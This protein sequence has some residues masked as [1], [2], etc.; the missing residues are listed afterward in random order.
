MTPE[1]HPAPGTQYTFYKLVDSNGNDIKQMPAL[2][3]NV[4]GLKAWYNADDKCRGFN[5][6]G[7]MKNV[8]VDPS[9]FNQWAADTPENANKGLYVKL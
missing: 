4:E 7:W 5:T 1:S 2:A 6:N 9:K 8:I 3:N